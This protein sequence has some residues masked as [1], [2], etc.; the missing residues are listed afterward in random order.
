[1][2]TM[3]LDA[4]FVPVR[5]FKIAT[6]HPA[7]PKSKIVRSAIDK[8]D[9]VFINS[10]APLGSSSLK[11]AKKISKPVIEFIHSIDWELFAYA[12]AFP[13]KYAGALK[14]IVR[15]LYNKSDLLLVAN[16]GL[17]TILHASKINNTIKI[18]PLGVDIKKFKQDRI[19]RVY[20]RREL[21]LKDNFVIGY[22]GRL[23]KEK[24]IKMLAKAFEKFR[25]KV[26]EAK[27]LIMGDGKEKKYLKGNPNILT[28]G[29]VNNPED[30]LQAIDIYVLPSMTET[31]GLA[32][33]EAMACG[34]ACIATNVGAIPSYVRDGGNGILLDKNKIDANLLALAIEKLHRNIKLRNELK[35]N[36]SKSIDCCYTW[37][38]TTKELEKFFESMIK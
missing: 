34:L 19:K 21:R 31:T 28:T 6:Y 1:M 11:Y 10:V 12:T 3:N 2:K 5:R 37:E 38:N 8:T 15:R 23:S 32:L 24:N 26:P 30:Y 36:A 22:H 4:T 9:I 29:F 27:L 20:I 13:D 17:R 33:M 18:L 7:I 25:T 35:Q 14:P 16:K